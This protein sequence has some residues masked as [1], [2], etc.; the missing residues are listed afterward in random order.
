MIPIYIQEPITWR[1]IEVPQEIIQHCSE[2]TQLNPYDIDNLTDE[3]RLLDCYWYNMDYY[4]DIVVVP[5]GW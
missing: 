1:E 3:L 4:K 2:F 5:P